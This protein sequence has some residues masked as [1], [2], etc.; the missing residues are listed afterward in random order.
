MSP[1]DEWIAKDDGMIA[2]TLTERP[3]LTVGRR[4]RRQVGY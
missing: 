4:N 3:R 2:H 1:H